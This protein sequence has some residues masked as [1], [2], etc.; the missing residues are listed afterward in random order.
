MIGAESCRL[1]VHN[2]PLCLGFAPEH[3][4]ERVEM[5]GCPT[6]SPLA[7][8]GRHGKGN[9]VFE[10]GTHVSGFAGSST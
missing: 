9:C 1:R 7:P 6:F 3:H 5:Y 2:D 8:M 10:G 4:P